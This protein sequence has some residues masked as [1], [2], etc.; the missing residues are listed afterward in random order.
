LVGKPGEKRPLERPELRWEDNIRT[1]LR[2]IGWKDVDWMQMVQ[3]R[4]K[5]RSLVNTV[6]KLRIPQKAGTS[7]TT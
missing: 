3:D 2:E 4:D 5:W 1:D 7:L 6:M